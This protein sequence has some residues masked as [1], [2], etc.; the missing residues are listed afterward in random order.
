LVSMDKRIPLYIQLRTFVLEQIQQHH[1]LSG[2][3]LPSENEL[4][5]QFGVSRITVKNA[6]K[7]LVKEGL[8]YRIQG[9]GSFVAAPGAGEP[10]LLSSESNPGSPPIIAYLMPWLR[11]SFTANLLSGVEE[12]LVKSGYNVLFYRTHDSQQTEKEL[13]HQVIQ[14]GV[15]GIII[16]P[17]DG[18]HYN[19]ELVQLTLSRF[20]IVLID[21]EMRGIA[22][23]SVCSD[24]SGGAYAATKY[25]I[26]QGHQQIAFITSSQHGTISVEERLIGYEKALS[27]HGLP[28]HHS[29][30]LLHAGANDIENFLREH[31]EITAVFAENT[32]TGN[33]VIQN[34]AKLNLAIPERL[35]LVFFDDFEYSELSR[36]PPT[37]IVQQE[38]EIGK[39]AAKL[40][41]SLINNP[42]QERKKIVLPSHLIVRQSTKAHLMHINQ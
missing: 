33:H 21:R 20:P 30:R 22:A 3:R 7:T 25:L 9:R 32:G 40:L 15:K 42:M 17:V 6:L 12:E 16:F 19:E 13:I 18:E 26:E 10:A 29:L 11:N 14:L 37:V 34:A 41:I 28:I 1:W 38:E 5:N 35:S 23:N 39:E 27:D 2:D 31:N 24:H 36:I 8:I 4:A